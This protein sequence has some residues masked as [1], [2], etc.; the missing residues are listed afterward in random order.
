MKALAQPGEPW[1]SHRPVLSA[2]NAAP[3]RSQPAGA[4]APPI[5]PSRRLGIVPITIASLV[6]GLAIVA[7]ILVLN[8]QPKAT[9][10]EVLPAAAPMGIPTSGFVLGKADAPV[11]IEIYESEGNISTLRRRSPRAWPPSP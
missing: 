10:A 2:A 5:Q 8:G 3:P 7:A 11:T 1:S 6:A 4:R 9:G